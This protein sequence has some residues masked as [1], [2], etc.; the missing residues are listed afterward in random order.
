MAACVAPSWLAFRPETSTAS[1]MVLSTVATV[2]LA[3]ALAAAAVVLI[4]AA[5]ALHALFWPILDRLTYAV[6][7]YDLV[8]KKKALAG[9]GIALVALAMPG[10]GAWLE[11]IRKLF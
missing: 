5:L 4:A 10:L 8:R 1:G 2:N 3:T 9:G 7:R 6:A 11:A